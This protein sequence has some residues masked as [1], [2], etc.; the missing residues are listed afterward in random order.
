MIP[1]STG[2]FLL[3]VSI[4]LPE[5]YRLAFESWSSSELFSHLTDTRIIIVLNYI[6]CVD[7][8][9]WDFCNLG[10]VIASC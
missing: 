10:N 2:I 1:T 7:P 9:I 6:I 8:F 4:L 3:N 5:P